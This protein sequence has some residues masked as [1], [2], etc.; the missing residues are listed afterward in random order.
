MATRWCCKCFACA[1]RGSSRCGKS[2]ELCKSLPTSW[3]AAANTYKNWYEPERCAFYD[4]KH[5]ANV[6]MGTVQP[7]GWRTTAVFCRHNCDHELLCSTCSV[8]EGT[9]CSECADHAAALGHLVSP[10]TTT[11]TCVVYT[12]FLTLKPQFLRAITLKSR[13]CVM[14]GEDTHTHPCHS[15]RS[16]GSNLFLALVQC[17]LFIHCV[18]FGILS[19]T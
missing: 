5:A 10:P 8:M 9:W 12:P 1:L 2:V 3:W 7:R 16:E 4:S 18:F 13:S 19:F 11:S 14:P 15:L 17:A 6:C